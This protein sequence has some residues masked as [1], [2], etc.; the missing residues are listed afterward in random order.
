MDRSQP[1]ELQKSTAR[2]NG[3]REDMSV[4]QTLRAATIVSIVALAMSP[5]SAQTLRYANQG[6]LKSL[7]P[8]TLNETT[9]H[10]HLGQV[11][12]GLIARD[13]DL[14]IIPALAES[15]ETPE[16]TRWRFHL[17]KGV[18]FQNGDPFT[19]DDVV[20]SG[21]RVRAKGSNLQTRIPADAKVVKVDDYTVDFILTSPNPILHS[22][23]D[24]WYIMD[25]KWAEE[26][27]SA[28]PT[29]AA[30]TSPSF[31][32]LHANGT[33]AFTVESHQP[34]VK[35]VFK[36]NPNWWQKP[37]HN[38]K[39][40]VFTPIG[41]DAT[42][43]AALLSGE[44]DIIEPVPIQ[45]ISRVDSSPNAQVLKGPELRTIFLGM[46]Q[47]RD[48]LL[49]SNVKGKNPFKDIRVRE[50]FFRAIDIELIKTR[51]MR[52]LSTPSALMIAP[53]LF[54]LS[55]D[56]TRP[57]F[58]PD[59]AKKLLTEAGYPDGFEVTMDCPNDRYVNDA[60]ICQAVVGML[61]RIGVKV[62]LLAQPKAQYFA[63]VLKPGGFQT[64]FYLLGWTPGT[65]DAHNVLYDIMG[66]RDDPKSSRGEANLGGYCNK[67]MDEITDKV[68]VESDP[69][70]RDLLIKEAFEIAAK[71]Y[72]YI[73]LHQ[74]AL[75]WGVS[76]KLKVVQ[77]ADNAVLPYWMTKQE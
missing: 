19:A 49:Y 45:D 75:A 77:R 33:G 28:A 20:F 55:G 74:Q 3:E 52:G 61:A 54:K 24:T 1:S 17:R 65:S 56:F 53:Q 8:Y 76:K 43:I 46:D 2:H 37:E 32:S 72:A 41:S 69:G 14:K 67:K 64:S 36:A 9:T 26:N 6:E 70:K 30:A 57:K 38:L 29:P 50:A 18:K 60:A 5:A 40:I 48:E 31:A 11:Y 22:A 62:N 13:K 66:C 4:C 39:E 47:A 27:N 68:L 44:V 71:D 59:T 12:E 51:V 23:W 34:G 73:P 7:D 63:K 10:A 58:D 16:P 42:R 21:E 35:T 25:K 15:W